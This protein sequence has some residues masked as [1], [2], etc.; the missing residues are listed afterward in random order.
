[1]TAILANGAF[2]APGTRARELF[3]TAR[4]VVCCDGAADTYRAATGMECDLVVGDLDSLRSLPS[5]CIR[6]AEQETNDLEKAVRAC[7]ELGYRDLVIFGATGLRD[8]HTLGNIFRALA[9]GVDIAT[10]YG[11]FH[12][13]ASAASFSCPPG[14]SV[15][16]FASNPAT[17]CTSTGLEW[18]LD[19]V[20]F[21]NLYCATLNRTSGPEFS[22]STTHPVF[23][24]IAC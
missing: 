24:Y 15:S 11:Y 16:I 19:G 2:P 8:D 5:N 20:R 22:I 18:P 10:D 21:E 12:F 13:V 3:D 17:R 7:R 23:V 1:M 9:L 14:T 4:R 6:I